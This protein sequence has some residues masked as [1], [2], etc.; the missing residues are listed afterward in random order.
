[1]EYLSGKK[2][3]LIR[4]KKR[5][6]NGKFLSLTGAKCFGPEGEK[7]NFPITCDYWLK[8]GDTPIDGIEI[9]KVLNLKAGKDVGKI[10]NNIKDAILDG[11]I[12][13]NYE[14]AFKYMMSIKDQLLN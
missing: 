13:N 2:E 4:K 3:I 11:K 5:L 7:K 6:G 9:M 14:D 12:E 10:K 1:M 8:D